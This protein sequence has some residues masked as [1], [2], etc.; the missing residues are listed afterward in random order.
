MDKASALKARIQEKGNFLPIDEFM[1]FWL[2]DP[3]HGYYRHENPL[4][5]QGDF[6]TAPE[7][8][9]L[10]G[11]MIA[12]WI[13]AALSSDQ[14]AIQLLELGPGTGRLMQDVR[15]T[16]MKVT[17]LAHFNIHLIEINHALRELQVKN[18]EHSNT[19]LHHQEFLHE[20]LHAID[21]QVPLFI[22]ANEYFDALPSKEYL[23]EGLALCERGVKVN[24]QGD[25]EFHPLSKSQSIIELAPE[26]C[27]QFEA[28]IACIKNHQACAKGLVIDYGYLQAQLGSSIQAMVK[29]HPIEVLNPELKGDLTTHVDFA[30]FLNLAHDMGIAH[31][32]T[33]QGHFLLSLGLE[34]RVNRAVHKAPAMG[35]KLIG[36]LQ[37]LT[38][39]HEM[40]TLFKVL[41]ISNLEN[42]PLI[43][44]NHQ[45]QEVK[46]FNDLIDE[47]LLQH[48]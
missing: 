24:H 39:P 37:R 9:S 40:G 10:F 45:D 34:L 25:F 7:I 5:Y 4:S 23:L 38:S 22:I 47:Y 46:S 28:V 35:E 48:T 2:H 21:R 1:R 3:V 26:R 18:L 36:C 27:H 6:T 13:A 42:D 43:V 17:A 29:G 19:Q 15:A 31:G 30:S 41:Q 32:I 20:S 8:S 14:K 16:L 11:E 33:T 44:Q 12:L